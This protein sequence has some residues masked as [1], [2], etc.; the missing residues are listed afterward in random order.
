[1]A[2]MIKPSNLIIARSRNPEEMD[3]PTGPFQRNIDD[4]DA[5]KCRK[6]PKAD[7]EI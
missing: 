6:I 4:L 7:P 1:M 2:S 3:E 5:K